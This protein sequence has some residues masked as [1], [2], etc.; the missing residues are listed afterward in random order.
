M[1]I[2]SIILTVYMKLRFKVE[3]TY[4]KELENDNRDDRS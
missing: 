2:I 4:N 1:Y 3:L